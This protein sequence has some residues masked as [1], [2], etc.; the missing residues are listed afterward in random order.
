MSR[1]GA[2]IL[3][4]CLAVLAEGPA[5]AAITYDWTFTVQALSDGFQGPPDYLGRTLGSGTLT[6]AA[7]AVRETYDDGFGDTYAA[8]TY[9]VTGIDG[10][11]AGAPITGLAP[12]GGAMAVITTNGPFAFTADNR[13]QVLSTP[14]GDDYVLSP[15]GVLVLD[16]ASAVDAGGLTTYA[17]DRLS[18]PGLQLSLQADP[19]FGGFVDTQRGNEWQGAL[20]LTPV[21]APPA[22]GVPEPAAWAELIVGSGM[23]GAVL[24]LR[25]RRRARPAA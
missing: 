1:L 19:F 20:T 9:A 25:R 7:T 3:G 2:V 12:Q 15:G 21:G 23:L 14:Y 17:G 10:T 24:R 6:T 18:T 13:L 16:L 8:R 5:R 22:A 4:L 11:L